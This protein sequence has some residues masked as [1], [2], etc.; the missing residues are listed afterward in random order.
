MIC[1]ILVLFLHF[2]SRQQVSVNGDG[3]WYTELERQEVISPDFGNFLV[4]VH[5]F[6]FW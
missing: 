2:F 4:F 1:G 6:F 3:T 5:N